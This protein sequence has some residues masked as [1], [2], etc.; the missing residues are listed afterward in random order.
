MISLHFMVSAQVPACTILDTPGN[1]AMNVSVNTEIRWQARANVTRYFLNI[2]TTPGGREVEDM[3]DMGSAL[4]Y[5]A[6]SG[7]LENTTYYITIIPSNNSGNA[8]NCPEEQF[9]TGAASSIPGCVT[10]LDPVD[11]A[12]GVPPETNLSWAPQPEA[13]GY[14]L[15]V[16]TSSGGND[17]VD[18]VDVGNVT[19]YD[20]PTDLPPFQ[21]VYVTII[22]YNAAG[23]Q[24]LNCS[25]AEFRTRGSNPP[26]CTEIINPADGDQFV[27]VTAN[28]TW[29]RDFGASG[30][31]MTIE[32]KS[33]GGVKILDNFD[34]GNGTNFKPP[35]FEGNTLYFVTLTPYNDLGP[36]TGCQ[37][38]SFTTGEGLPP[39][40][41]IQLLNP[42]NGAIDV[43]TDTS[44]EWAAANGATGYILNVGT[45]PGGRSIVNREDVGN[46]T[47]YNF[48]E[49]LPE[50]RK[51]YVTILPYRNSAE[52]ENCSFESFTTTGVDKLE[53]PAPPF[54]TPNNDGFNDEW[55]VASVPD[56][57]IRHI[58]IF[59]RYGQLLKQLQVNEGWDGNHNGKPLA[60][61][62]YWYRIETNE[63]NSF[64][65]YFMLKR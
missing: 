62:S 19:T 8:V 27:S 61:D 33:I 32:E 40:D 28:I 6:P 46:V 36:A 29:I 23:E 12:T 14:I 43:S 1:G 49:A 22:P 54:F 37:P 64:V 11:G 4:V 7:L 48:S 13:S 9:M 57:E 2:G 17:L 65:G 15:T 38:I 56:I 26:L 25:E 63:G 51:I 35:D 30:Y 58:T 34:V 24:P 21:R 52:A 47:A 39:P 10:I 53:V 18:N 50:G 41:C 42:L 55:K 3:L 44:L 45:S 59:N 5:T 31:L 20:L 16:G 60:S